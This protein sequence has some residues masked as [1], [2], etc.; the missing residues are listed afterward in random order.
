M[1]LTVSIRFGVSDSSGKRLTVPDAHSAGS[2]C[3]LEMRV[4]AMRIPKSAKTGNARARRIE[5][6]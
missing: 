2:N 6:K 5:I 4:L 3:N 1:F